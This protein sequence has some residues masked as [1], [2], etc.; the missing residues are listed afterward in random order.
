M[1]VQ[2]PCLSSNLN[3]FLGR[4]SILVPESSIDIAQDAAVF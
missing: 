2:F 3:P 4:D 1:I